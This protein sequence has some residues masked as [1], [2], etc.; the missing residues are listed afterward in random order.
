[1][2]AH[3]AMNGKQSGMQTERCSPIG[4]TRYDNAGKKATV[5]ERN[6]YLCFFSV[7]NAH[8]CPEVQLC[9]LTSSVR[10]ARPVR[11]HI[12]LK[13]HMCM[14]RLKHHIRKCQSVHQWLCL[15]SELCFPPTDLP[16]KAE[17]L[18]GLIRLAQH[19]GAISHSVLHHGWQVK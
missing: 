7:D 17:N 8:A 11:L 12:P 14:A 18:K 9:L 5:R 1:M 3:D 10:D 6:S 15:S 19:Q 13:A 16:V 2:P 4:E